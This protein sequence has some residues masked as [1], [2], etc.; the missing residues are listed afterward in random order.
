MAHLVE[1]SHPIREVRGSDPVI[2]KIKYDFT[3]VYIL[4]SRTSVVAKSGNLSELQFFVSYFMLI[5]TA[6]D[7]A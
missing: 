7:A 2:G 3:R 5:P 1:R 6:A 4:S